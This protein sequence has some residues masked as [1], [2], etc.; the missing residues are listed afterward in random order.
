[1][2][3]FTY[4][5]RRIIGNL[6]YARLMGMKVGQRVTVMRNVYFGS[7]PYL[8]TLDDEVRISFDVSF[9]THD[10]GTWVFRNKEKYSNVTSFG[11]I[12]VGKR[13]FI[14]AKS[15]ILPNVYIGINCVIGAGSV[16]TRSIPDNSIA[17]GTPAKVIGNVNSYSEKLLNKTPS[18]WN[19][20]L[21]K[22]NKRKYL[23]LNIKPPTI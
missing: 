18:N 12:F 17:V 6:P 1:M 22:K 10:G 13:T 7:E 9:I 5:F 19:S 16:V 11:K 23:E 21:Y 8:I 4:F 2:K 20:K 15:I 14:G 3:L